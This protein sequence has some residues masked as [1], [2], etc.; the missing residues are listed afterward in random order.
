MPACCFFLPAARPLLHALLL[1]GVAHGYGV[2]LDRV[3]VAKAEAFCKGVLEELLQRGAFAGTD[4]AA[5]AAAGKGDAC[6]KEGSS[7]G[8]DV[9]GAAVDQQQQTPEESVGSQPCGS[10]AATGYADSL[11]VDASSSQASEAA[12]ASGTTAA[13]A[14]SHSGV[15]VAAGGAAAA[16]GSGKASCKSSKGK[17][18]LQPPQ[19]SP[20][21]TCASI[22][23]VGQQGREGRGCCTLHCEQNCWC[24]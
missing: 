4:T 16:G 10:D 14:A 20:I 3:K 13:A 19:S 21:I 7:K 2:E 1:Q 15:A 22:E 18:L 5:A 9:S 8:A 17:G 12:A 23:Q 11:S 24:V 6:S